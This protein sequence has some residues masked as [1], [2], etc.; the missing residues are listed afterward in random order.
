RA[1]EAFILPSHQENFGVS[2]VESLA[3]RRPVLISNQVNI[4]QEI[5]E[6]QVGLV[7]DDTVEGAERL[8]R[9]W[10]AMPRAERDAMSA[11]TYPFFL[12]RYSMKNG[13]K[14][15]NQVFVQAGTKGTREQ[16]NKGA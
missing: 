16:G 11:R 2:V 9:R 1:A 4:W 15:I 14:A 12:S 10:L 8:M 13:A 5:Q 6:A 7:D 3:A